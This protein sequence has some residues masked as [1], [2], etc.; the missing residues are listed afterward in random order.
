MTTKILI[1]KEGLIVRDPGNFNPL[2][3]AGEEK[4]WIGKEGRYWRRRVKDGTVSILEIKTIKRK[5]KK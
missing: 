3:E 1:P 4:P 2:A 5:L